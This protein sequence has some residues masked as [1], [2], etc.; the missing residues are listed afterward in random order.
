VSICVVSKDGDG[1]IQRCID[2]IF[3][4]VK[5]HNFEVLICDTGTTDQKV[6]DYYETRKNDIKIFKDHEYNFSKNNNFLAKKASGSMLLFMNNDVFLTYDAISEMIKYALCSNI[7]CLGHRLVWDEAQ[8]EIQHDGQVLFNSDGSWAGP[9]HHNYKMNIN[10]LSNKNIR[11]EGVTAAFLMIRKSVFEQ[12]KGFDE[13]YKDIYQDVDLNL[14]VRKAGYDN[15]CIRSKALIHVDHG[16][17]KDD[18]TPDS[19]NDARKFYIDWQSKGDFPIRKRKKYCILICATNENQ[20]RTLR[21]SIKTREEYEFIY[22]NNTSNYLW[23]SEALNILTEVSEGDIIFWTHQDVTFD[24]YEPF[25][26]ITNII[27]QIGNNFGILGPAGIQVGGKG[28][29]RGVDFSSLK[30]NFDFLKVQTIDEFCLIGNRKN[31]L[32][33]DENLDHF[34]FYGADIC[35]QALDNKLKNYVIKIPITHHSG[36]DV[37]LKKKGGYEAY[38]K[39][40]RKFFKKWEKRFQYISTTT[41]HYRNSKAFWYLGMLLGLTPYKETIDFENIDETPN[42]KIYQK[43]KIETYLDNK[44]D[45]CSVIILNKDKPELITKC[46]KLLNDHIKQDNYEILIGDTGSTNEETLKFYKECSENINVIDAGEYQFSKNNNFVV[47]QAKYN[48]VLF[49]NNDVF[50]NSD[51]IEKMSK[52][53]KQ[54]NAIVGTKLLYEDGTIQHGG[55]EMVISKERNPNEWYLPEHMYVK[56]KN[57]EKENEIVDCV[58][59][60]CLMMPTMLFLEYNGFDEKYGKV[61]QDVDLCLKM[62]R[63][64]YTCV[65]CNEIWSTHLESATR[66]PEINTEDYNLMT[67]RW[68]KVKY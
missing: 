55:V 62:K 25:A 24:G 65:C 64:G 4:H 20:I 42:V 45:G 60:A 19:P 46:V 50:I 61:F 14:K 36:G 37:N 5:Y 18:S 43:N 21:E 39:Q 52:L 66:D 53:L 23:S 26:A 47:K 30:Y 17:R 11:V 27:N 44:E 34:H 49:L 35:C 10:A 13:D 31:N 15:F 40:G 32:K 48:K 38:L 58:T 1:I 22:V 67:S 59:G 68:G 29:I 33:F 6:L 56:S 2:N 41:V 3:R 16:T 7:G 12:V 28:A 54:K 9:G 57:F 51:I 63:L 8:E